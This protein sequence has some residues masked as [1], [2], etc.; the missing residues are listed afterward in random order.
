M[1]IRDSIGDVGTL[2]PFEPLPGRELCLNEAIPERPE[3]TLNDLAVSHIDADVTLHPMCIRD[4]TTDSHIED[5]L[6][7]FRAWGFRYVTVA[8][9]WKKV[10]I[11]GKTLS[12]LSQWTLKNC[13]LCLFGTRGRMLQYKKANNVQPVSYTHL[14]RRREIETRKKADKGSK[15][16]ARTG[17]PQPGELARHPA[18]AERRARHHTQAH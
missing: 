12:N 14:Y 6:K 15:N 13:E 17:G 9:V 7:L 3:R 5:A 8:F 2:K 16:Q 1:C 18:E 4:R 11:N 10:S